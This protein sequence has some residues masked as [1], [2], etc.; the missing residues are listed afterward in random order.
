MGD[1]SEEKDYVARVGLKD[2][3]ARHSFADA[4]R[5]EIY[6]NCDLSFNI[7]NC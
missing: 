6:G 4:G 2:W 7:S 3:P 5:R 1:I